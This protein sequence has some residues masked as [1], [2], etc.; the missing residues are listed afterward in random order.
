MHRNVIYQSLQS[1]Y[2]ASIGL[3]SGIK[4]VSLNKSR[5]KIVVKD[6]QIKVIITSVSFLFVTTKVN[7]KFN[8][9]PMLEIERILVLV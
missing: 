6:F 4:K 9:L 3:I 1:I 2:S 8:I 5:R 7:T